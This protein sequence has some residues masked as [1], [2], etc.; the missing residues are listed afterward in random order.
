M[1]TEAIEIDSYR[2]HESDTG[3]PE[4]QVAQLTSRIKHLTEHLKANKKDYA[5]QRGLLMLVGRRRRL[6]GY[7]RREDVGR[8]Q[9][10]ISD[11]GLRR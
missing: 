2:Q 11:L 6:L 10:L 1:S 5:T 8:Y 9:K 7:L 4:V 3:S